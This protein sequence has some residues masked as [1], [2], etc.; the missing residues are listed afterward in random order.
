[1]VF[2]FP[3]TA[4]GTKFVSR[5]FP[6]LFFKNQVKGQEGQAGAG[7]QVFQCRSTVTGLGYDERNTPMEA[8]AI[9]ELSTG[10]YC[11]GFRTLNE[12]VSPLWVGILSFLEP[13]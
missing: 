6:K 12:V 7:T 4:L 11:D 8:Q 3:H 13:L 2:I 10:V 9:P 5:D 1:M